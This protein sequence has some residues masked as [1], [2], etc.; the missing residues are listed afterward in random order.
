[1]DNKRSELRKH[2]KDEA[3]KADSNK[4]HE[5]RSAQLSS[6][7]ET[8]ANAFGSLLDL[9]DK[10]I[11]KT[12]L[13]NQLDTIKTPDVENVVISL[14]K[15]S[16]DVLSTKLDLKPLTEALNVVKRELS[17]IPKKLP[18]FEQKE[19]VKVTN[20]SEIKFDTS[21]VEK[22]IKAL[23]LK[24]D[25]KAP[26]VNVEKTD[27]EP[28]RQVML[29]LLKAINKQEPTE[30]VKVSNLKDIPV[31]NLSKVE[32]KLDESNKQLKIIAE[33]KSGAGGGGGNGSPYIDSNGVTKNVV[34]TTDG[35]IPVES[36]SPVGGSTEAK[37]DDQIT[38]LANI[39]T[40]L[41]NKTEASQNQQVELINAIRLISIAIANPSYV[42]KS[43]NQMRAQ[44]T[45]S[46]TATVAST[47]VSSI[48]SFP[49][50]HLQRMN[51]MTA[52]ATSVRQIIT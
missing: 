17:L 27:I 41:A 39:L 28:L 20:L 48:G 29:D 38:Q 16:E 24:V 34:L 1:M 35:K 14:Q 21:A 22:A 25:V 33:K 26:I 5:E 19:N 12:E 31:S 3:N 10:K 15:L 18:E 45:G 49:G 36:A 50:D 52:W 11:T 30:T 42:D 2:F 37:Q 47:V 6:I 23:D 40:E 46:V 43:A 7:E 9:I 32:K 4:M 44:V 8:I 51:N 13:I